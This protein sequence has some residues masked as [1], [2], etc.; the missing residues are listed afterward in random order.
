[1]LDI[2]LAGVGEA[3]QRIEAIDAAELGDDLHLNGLRI[4]VIAR[5]VGG[6][7]MFGSDHQTTP[8]VGCGQVGRE[9]QYPGDA[10]N[11]KARDDGEVATA[12]AKVMA[13][14]VYPTRSG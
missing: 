13:C 12:R 3:L 8:S 9:Q 2:S 1:M 6:A 10:K 11:D 4:S 5:I 7:A 14:H